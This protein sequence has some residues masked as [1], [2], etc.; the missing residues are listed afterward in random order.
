MLIETPY[1]PLTQDYQKCSYDTSTILFNQA[2]SS[3]GNVSLLAPLCIAFILIC[4]SCAQ[5]WGCISIK[6]TYTDT[7]KAEALSDLA[8]K[9]LLTRDK[10]EHASTAESSSAVNDNSVLAKL[11][12]ELAEE[13]ADGHLYRHDESA[14]DG[15]LVTWDSVKSV[16]GLNKRTARDGK[17][18][19]SSTQSLQL[20]EEGRR[21][22]DGASVDA[23]STAEAGFELRPISSPLHHFEDVADAVLAMRAGKNKFVVLNDYEVTPALQQKLGGTSVVTAEGAGNGHAPAPQNFSVSALFSLLDS[24]ISAFEAAGVD[25]S[26]SLWTQVSQTAILRSVPLSALSRA[27]SHTLYLKLNTLLALHATVVFGVSLE[28]VKRSHAATVAYLVGSEP[29]T[30]EEIRIRL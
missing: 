9:L 13:P 4:V 20:E 30:L 1:A 18:G 19:H 29:L 22:A 7:E 28:E 15:P 23:T 5:M 21:G 3:V 27:D 2:G 26:R 8:L 6:K 25:K 12:S 16:V 11:V 14:A 24:L 10:K 17:S